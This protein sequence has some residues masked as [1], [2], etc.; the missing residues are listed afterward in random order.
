MSVTEMALA[1][2]PV[3][4]KVRTGVAWVKCVKVPVIAT[5]VS[6]CP[7][8]PE[9]GFRLVRTGVPVPTVKSPEPVAVSDPVTTV[10]L[11]DPAVAAGEIVR[12]A[13][14]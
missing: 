13:V 11:D 10:T 6:V 9:D 8:N 7:W 3:L 1:T 4:L 2:I 14:R 5:P 12:V